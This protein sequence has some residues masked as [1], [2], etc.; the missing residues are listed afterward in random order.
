M[1]EKRKHIL[2]G[3]L[4]IIVASIIGI[5][6]FYWYESINYVSTEDARVTGDLIKVSPKGTGKLLDISM[7]EGDVVIKEQIL[8]R[9]EIEDQN[10]EKAIV[11]APQ[12]GVIVKKQANI[13]ETYS[14]GQALGYIV[15]PE[16]LYI[17]A[18]IEEKKIGSI[19]AGQ[20]VDI[21][22][23]EFK[24]IKFKGKVTFVGLAANSSFSLL[25]A[26]SGGTFTKTV[27]RVPIKI[28]I[29][30]QGYKILPGTNSVVKIHLKK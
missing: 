3:L 7:E 24:G 27:Q 1:K 11:R 19:R 16:K 9:Q 30:D 10:P 2:I 29:E 17:S 14:P 15:D 20:T 5:S 6:S 23:D 4:C 22:I 12:K 28:S 26:S 21:T 25:P 18:N 8:G 13:G